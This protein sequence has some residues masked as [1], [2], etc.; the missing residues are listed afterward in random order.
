MRDVGRG[1]EAPERSIRRA[2][3]SKEHNVRALLSLADVAAAGAAVECGRRLTLPVDQLRADR[4]VAVSGGWR[5][6]AGGLVEREGE[7]VALAVLIPP[8]ARLPGGRLDA[9]A[10]VE[11][12]QDLST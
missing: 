7:E 11:R 5:E 6:R 3:S 2:Q 8:D 9:R 4:V 12:G 1:P 10:N